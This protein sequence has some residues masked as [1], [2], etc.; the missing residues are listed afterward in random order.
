MRLS[1][2]ETAQKQHRWGGDIRSS[3]RVR[4]NAIG[5]LRAQRSGPNGHGPASARPPP[6]RSDLL[7]A[8]ALAAVPSPQGACAGFSRPW[9]HRLRVRSGLGLL[10]QAWGL[11]TAGVASFLSLFSSFTHSVVSDARTPH[12]FLGCCISNKH[13]CRC[14]GRLRAA[15][16]AGRGPDYRCR[17]CGMLHG[18][19]SGRSHITPSR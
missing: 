11:C 17:L 3:C 14:K 5:A 4:L 18:T 9:Q 12:G 8:I 6:A 13:V 19:A 15:Y 10:R 2:L 16:M 1:R 7:C